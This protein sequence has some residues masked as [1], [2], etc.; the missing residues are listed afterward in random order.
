MRSNHQSRGS[1]LH[2]AR[3]CPSAYRNRV[4]LLSRARITAP[5]GEA[6]W[7]QGSLGWRRNAEN[8]VRRT[9]VVAA[10]NEYQ[11]R[12]RLVRSRVARRKR[13]ELA[14][15]QVGGVWHDCDFLVCVH[16]SRIA[17][18]GQLDDV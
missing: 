13:V 14:G 11:R 8:G 3:L 6:D 2:T 16:L 18:A 15:Y 12:A 10:A 4:R 1:R 7:A 5:G 17:R 9:R